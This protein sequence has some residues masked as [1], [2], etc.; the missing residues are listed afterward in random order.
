MNARGHAIRLAVLAAFCGCIAAGSG[1]PR[2]HGPDAPLDGRLQTVSSAVSESDDRPPSGRP[3][4]SGRGNPLAAIPREALR[5]TRERPL[6]SPSRSPTPAVA[7]TDAAVIAVT[8]REA[9]PP[10]QAPPVTLVGVI[11]GP[12][13]E[14]AV[15]VEGSGGPAIR[16][17]IGDPLCGWT[18]SGIEGKAVTLEKAGA[19]MKLELHAGA[20]A[21][22]TPPDPSAPL[23]G[24]PVGPIT[25][26]ATAS[27]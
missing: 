24:M 26:F 4:A 20:A 5:A 8:A 3:P 19:F 12:G 21:A 25:P 23:Q 16:V 2:G 7:A 14:M 17:R 13:L 9:S 6:F 11:K 22:A 18:V 27:R 10:P 1:L 15:F